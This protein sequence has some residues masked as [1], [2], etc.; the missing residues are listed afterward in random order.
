MGKTGQ[1][2]DSPQF[3][4]NLTKRSIDLNQ[5]VRSSVKFQASME[6]MSQTQTS[7]KLSEIRDDKLKQIT[8]R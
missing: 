6:K 7:Q 8:K 2:I 1:T 4:E 5:T 3:H